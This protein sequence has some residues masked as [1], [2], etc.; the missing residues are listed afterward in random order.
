[1]VRVLRKHGYTVEATDLQ[2]GED[3]LLR[4]ER[5]ANVVTNPPYRLAQEFVAHARRIATRKVAMLLPVEFLHG[6]ARYD[7]F[8]ERTF[9]LKIVY[10]F[11]ARLCFGTDTPATVGHAW[12]VWD[13]N[14]HGEPRIGWIR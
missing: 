5:T 1:M 12:Y 10:V 8:Q 4:S 11:A 13:R 14:C 6:V 9:P 3:F 7:L 2:Y